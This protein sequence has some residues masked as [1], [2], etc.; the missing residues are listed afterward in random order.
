MS[1]RKSSRARSCRTGYGCPLLSM[2]PLSLVE[3]QTLLEHWQTLHWKLKIKNH[4]SGLLAFLRLIGVSY[5]KKYV[6][7]FEEDSPITHFQKVTDTTLIPLRQHVM[8]L[9][10]IRDTIWDRVAFENQ[11]LPSFDALHLHWEQS[12]WVMHMWGQA[13]KNRMTLL[14]LTHYGWSVEDQLLTIVWDTDENIAT[15]HDRVALL[16][17]GCKCKGGCTTRRC[18]CRKNNNKCSAGCQC[19]NCHNASELPTHVDEL[20]SDVDS[21]DES[22]HEELWDLSDSDENLMD[23]IFGPSSDTGS[24]N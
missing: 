19:I 10:E 12:C 17:Q 14:P 21:D 23:Q 3:T 13:S 15:V 2:P 5:F 16:T 11:M 20:L 4:R 1:T 18:K 8:W 22:N 6:S 9:S 24:E 7:S